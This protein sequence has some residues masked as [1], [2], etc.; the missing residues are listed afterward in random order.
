[1]ILCIGFEI[2]EEL[3]VVELYWILYVCFYL[4]FFKDVSLHEID[5][6]YIESNVFGFE[7]C[8]KFF[9]GV[10]V[11]ECLSC[12]VGEEEDSFF[13]FFGVGVVAKG[14]DA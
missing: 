6:D 1:M 13:E 9:I 4:I 11:V 2:H 8:G 14:V 5:G 3:G 7:L 10:F 12:S